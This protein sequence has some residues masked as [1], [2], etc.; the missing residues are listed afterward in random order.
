MNNLDLWVATRLIELA[1]NAE[2][3]DGDGVVAQQL[4]R[5]VAELLAPAEIGLLLSAEEGSVTV[6]AA[7]SS[8]ARDLAS[9]EA[10]QLAGPCTEC[11]SSAKPVLNQSVTMATAVQW[12][13]FAAAAHSMGFETVSALPILRGDHAIGAVSVLAAG[14]HRLSETGFRIAQIMTRAA[15]VLISQQR[16]LS[17]RARMA[18]QLQGA[19]ETRVVIEQAKGATAARLGITPDAA[20]DLLR[21]YA[22]RENLT[23][24]DIARQ[25]VLGELPAHEL[26]SSRRADTKRSES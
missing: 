4:T 18:E 13:A 5:D 7:S 26:F 6:P 9:L 24:A 25:T 16:E 19:L 23:L 8:R 3:G 1:E 17:V 2:A 21:G 11:M 22:R 14:D 10:Q 20:F 15:A 12:P